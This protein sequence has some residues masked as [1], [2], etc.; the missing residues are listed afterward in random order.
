M[1][2][3]SL[4]LLLQLQKLG[5]ELEAR[6]WIGSWLPFQSRQTGSDTWGRTFT[7]C[8]VP[9]SPGPHLIETARGRL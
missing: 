8:F 4:A 6:C 5:A 2:A 1:V 7:G 3:R 9:P